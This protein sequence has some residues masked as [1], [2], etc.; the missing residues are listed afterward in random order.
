MLFCCTLPESAMVC[1]RALNLLYAYQLCKIMLVFGSRWVYHCCRNV[2]GGGRDEYT[3]EM[4]VYLLFWIS[5]PYGWC[6]FFIIPCRGYSEIALQM[7]MKPHSTEYAK[8]AFR[9]ASSS[10]CGKSTQWVWIFRRIYFLF[11]N[12]AKHSYIQFHWIDVLNMESTNQFFAATKKVQHFTFRC[13]RL[14]LNT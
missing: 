1:R 5:S 10:L 12:T 3:S 6:S 4:H 11:L 2:D 14:T 7:H 8:E 13:T 9:H